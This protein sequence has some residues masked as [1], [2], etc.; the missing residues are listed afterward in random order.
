[1]SGFITS[2]FL[3]QLSSP[4]APQYLCPFPLC[5]FKSPHF[6]KINQHCRSTH[7]TD[8]RYSPESQA[9]RVLPTC[10][11]F[12][13]AVPMTGQ[14]FEDLLSAVQTELRRRAPRAP[15]DVTDP[16]VGCP[17]G[18][19]LDTDDDLHVLWHLLYFHDEPMSPYPTPPEPG[20]LE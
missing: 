16:G 17:F 2:P 20:V 14:P 19:Q 18:C 12:G 3:L 7:S 6:D 15:L 9:G 4:G 8:L 1:M 5:G 11:L 13:V 10:V